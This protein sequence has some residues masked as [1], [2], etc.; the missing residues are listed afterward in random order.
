VPPNRQARC[1]V[2]PQ[3]GSAPALNLNTN[4][5]STGCPL[6][7]RGVGAVAC[8]AATDTMHKD[9]IKGADKSATAQRT[10]LLLRD[11]LC[12][13]IDPLSILERPPLSS[14][15]MIVFTRAQSQH[16]PHSIA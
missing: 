1:A 14:R 16:I 11:R 2:P 7:S 15:G 6:V 4:H 5:Q 13:T 9:K 10:A 8:F 12:I 3:P